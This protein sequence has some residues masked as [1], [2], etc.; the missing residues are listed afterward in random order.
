MVPPFPTAANSTHAAELRGILGGLRDKT[1]RE[2]EKAIKI[3]LE[4]INL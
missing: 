3:S 4:L 1:L 2:V